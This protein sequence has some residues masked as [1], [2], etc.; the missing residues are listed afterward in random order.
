MIHF[1]TAPSKKERL[2]SQENEHHENT[3]WMKTIMVAGALTV[4]ALA[5]KAYAQDPTGSIHG[6]IQTQPAFP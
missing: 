5:P 3:Q 1:A 2:R 4:C 6:H